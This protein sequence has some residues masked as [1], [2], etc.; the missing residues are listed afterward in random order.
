MHQLKSHVSLILLSLL[1]T[2]PASALDSRDDWDDLGPNVMIQDDVRPIIE[3]FD[4]YYRSQNSIICKGE[5]RASLKN[6]EF[7]DVMFLSARAQRP[8]LVEVAIV[9]ENSLFPT[10][11]FISNGTDLF[12]QSIRLLNY[13]IS[14]VAE[15][16]TDLHDRLIAR[17]APNVPVEIITS[18][19]SDSPM[20][21]LLQIDAEPG[22]VRLVGTNDVNGVVCNEI[23]VNE[24]GTHVWI[25]KELPPRLMRYQSSWALMKPRYLPE[26]S[27]ITGPSITIDFKS[28]GL[29]ESL[30]KPWEWTVPTT[31][32]RMAT[33]HEN[34]AA[35]GPESGFDS[36]IWEGRGMAADQAPS[37]TRNS[38]TGTPLRNTM[39]PLKPGSLAPD[40]SLTN[41]EGEETTLNSIRDGRPAAVLFWVPGGKFSRSSVPRIIQAARGVSEGVAIIPIGSPLTADEVATNK[42]MPVDLAG[43]C[44]PE[45]VASKRFGLSGTFALYLIDRDGKIENAYVG[46]TPRFVTRV[47]DLIK[48]LLIPS[49]DESE[50][51]DGPATE[52]DASRDGSDDGSL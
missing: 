10:D 41:Q 45:G 23:A 3:R 50:K 44:D 24:R 40:V 1:I 5:I 29:S 21:N 4:R 38:G 6:I 22:L 16:F 2:T 28:W 17:S 8:N 52:S 32:N 13:M 15:D 42:T 36:M 39:T 11:I 12:E 46:P 19:M 20:R 33:M 48:S 51:P 9:A 7:D 26:G 30:N 43:W 35:P 14:P 47:P 49:S 27:V 18:L 34:A 25:S 31:S 37:L